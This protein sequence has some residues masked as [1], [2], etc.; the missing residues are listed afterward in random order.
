MTR[1]AEDASAALAASESDQ[2]TEDPGYAALGA[3]PDPDRLL[4]EVT[5]KHALVRLWRDAGRS[6]RSSTGCEV[7]EAMVRELVVVYSNHPEFDPVWLFPEATSSQQRQEWQPG[8]G[9]REAPTE[10]GF[11]QRG[12]VVPLLK[13]TTPIGDHPA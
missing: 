3:A 1:L 5:A 8:E 9:T 7:A 6:S 12:N 4:R 2:T 11:P 13:A 10:G